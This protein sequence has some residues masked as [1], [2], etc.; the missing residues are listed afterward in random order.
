MTMLETAEH[1]VEQMYP[2][3]LARFRQWFAEFDGRAWDEQIEADAS[4]GKLGALAEEALSE[5]R[6]GKKKKYG[7]GNSG[8]ACDGSGAGTR[9]TQTTIANRN[10][11]CPPSL[12]GADIRNLRQQRSA[13]RSHPPGT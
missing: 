11:A 8:A 6:A 5:Y 1:V 12:V 2:D 9:P 10:V 4:A 3:E 13:R 7:N